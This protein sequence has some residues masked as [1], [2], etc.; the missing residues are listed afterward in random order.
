MPHIHVSILSPVV[1]SNRTGKL[2]GDPVVAYLKHIMYIK[3]T[4]YC[5]LTHGSLLLPMTKS[6]VC[7]CITV[8]LC[9]EWQWHASYLLRTS[10][11]SSD[12][13]ITY[14]VKNWPHGGR[15]RLPCV[16]AWWHDNTWRLQHVSSSYL[17]VFIY[18]TTDF[19]GSNPRVWSSF[20][21]CLAADAVDNCCNCNLCPSVHIVQL[22][23]YLTC[24]FSR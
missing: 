10:A 4:M 8:V 9:A 6:P 1:S 14:S 17:W 22:F 12:A 3:D 16:N 21:F 2:K 15:D 7:G 5:S 24:P 20:C 19:S 11:V 18:P 13:P 23:Q